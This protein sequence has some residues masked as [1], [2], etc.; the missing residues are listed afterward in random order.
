MCSG[1]VF[2]KRYTLKAHFRSVLTLVPRIK[3]LRH[4]ARKLY[5]YLALIIVWAAT[6]KEPIRRLFGMMSSRTPWWPNDDQ[7]HLFFARAL[8]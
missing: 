6:F 2:P 1:R 4:L 3:T 8:I 7:G 5:I